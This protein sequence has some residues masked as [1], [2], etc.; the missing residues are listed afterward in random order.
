MGKKDME[1]YKPGEYLNEG[2]VIE[3]VKPSSGMGYQIGFLAPAAPFVATAVV[4][5]GDFI[6]GGIATGLVMAVSSLIHSRTQKVDLARALHR[7]GKVL[8]PLPAGSWKSLIPFGHKIFPMEFRVEAIKPKA[9][10]SLNMSLS[11]DDVR[12]QQKVSYIVKKGKGGIKVYELTPTDPMESWDA[13]FVQ[14]IGQTIDR[15]R[16]EATSIYRKLESAKTIDIAN[17]K[18]QVALDRG[19]GKK[20]PLW[21]QNLAS[22]SFK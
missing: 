18:L 14:E 16:P 1:L 11:A 20:T 6:T 22:R 4:A 15:F 7:Q 12:N 3:Q 8:T 2:K 19:Q 5:S 17:A 9:V 10:Q 13:L 21:V